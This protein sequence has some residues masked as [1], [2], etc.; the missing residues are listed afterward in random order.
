VTIADGQATTQPQD[1]DCT[2]RITRDNLAKLVKG[3]LNP[4]TGVMMGKLKVSGD[5]S[6]A[7]K[8][9]QLLKS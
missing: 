6:V 5:V 4:T 7:M 8:L 2:I 9:S 3:R 1:T